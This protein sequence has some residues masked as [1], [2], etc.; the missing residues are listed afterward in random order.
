MLQEDLETVFF[1]TNEFAEPH[2]IDGVVINCTIDNDQLIKR[3][4]KEYDGISVGE[5]LIFVKSSDISKKLGQGM[6]II[7]DGRQMYVFNIREDMGV[8]EII[9][10][11]NLG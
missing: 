4:K 6:P 10:S 1:N 3:S 5:I 9:L 8:Y 7:F 2:S 11:Q